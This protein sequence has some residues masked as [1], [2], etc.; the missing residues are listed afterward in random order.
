[1][2]LCIHIPLQ[3]LFV[4]HPRVSILSLENYHFFPSNYSTI[5]FLFSLQNIPSIT[6]FWSQ[7]WNHLLVSSYKTLGSSYSTNKALYIPSLSASPTCR[8]SL[9]WG[10]YLGFMNQVSSR[11]RGC[12]AISMSITY[13]PCVHYFVF[14]ILS[15]INILYYATPQ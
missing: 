3:P 13:I 2:K 12:E 9:T 4:N 10:I 8:W 7:Q 1:M 6:D 14:N 15:L 11:M 5:S